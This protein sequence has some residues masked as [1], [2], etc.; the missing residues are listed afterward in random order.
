VALGA[1]FVLVLTGT[2]GAQAAVAG[3]GAPAV[4]AIAAVFV[5]GA[6]LERAGVAASLGRGILRVAGRQETRLILLFCGAAGLLSGFMNS[7]GA[8]AVLLPVAL[9][10]ARQAGVSPSKLL[11]PLA[12]GT[13]LGGNLTLISGPSNLLASQVLLD[14]GHRPLGLWEFLPLGMTFLLAGV[15]FLGLIGRRWLPDHG[16]AVLAEQARLADVYR[17]HERLHAVRIRAD[18]PLVGRTLADSD[19]GRAGGMTVL[20][21]DRQGQRVVAPSRDERLEAGDILVVAGRLDD[22]VRSATL[23]EAGLEVVGELP[24][25]ALEGGDVQL[26]ELI[27]APRSTLDGRTIREVGFRE[28]YGLTVVAVW[29]QG[30]PRRTGLLDLP[31][32]AGDALLVQGRRDR[33]GLLRRDPNFVVLGP[34]GTDVRPDRMPWALVA[35]AVLA[36]AATAG[37]PIVVATWLAAAVIVVSGCLPPDDVLRAVDWRVVV[38]TGAL[39]PLGTALQTTGA[40]R[41]LAEAALRVAGGGAL[42]ALAAVL[43]A[44]VVLNQLMP[45]VAAT[46]VLV[47]VAVQVAASL[48]VSPHALVMAVIAGTGTTVTPLGNPVNLMVMGPGGYRMGDY[49]RVGL[50]LAAVL[51]AVSLVLIPVVWPLR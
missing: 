44:S 49:L 27:L 15:A 45:S 13:R 10:A 1:T 37:V 35:L 16:P 21:V 11:L 43:L 48:S 50:P 4:A 30:R 46:A 41:A 31:L 29:Q 6:G 33:L 14:S 39:L 38:F 7:I 47:P 34:Y 18:S 24:A 36:V 12:L 40:A 28:R 25:D 23:Q 22:P 20:A 26:A 2:L 19:L 17:L 32:R 5:V 51:T 9:A 8:L 3:F 42:P